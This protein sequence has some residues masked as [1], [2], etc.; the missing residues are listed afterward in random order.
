M[1][2]AE[3][4]KHMIENGMVYNPPQQTKK[5]KP[6]WHLGEFNSEE[7]AVSFARSKGWLDNKVQV[8]R[9]EDRNGNEKFIVEPYEDDCHC[10]G[11][12]KPY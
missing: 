12:I 6:K 5:S 3:R 4:I 10:P 2:N 7:I 8:K 11:L 1:N 9:L